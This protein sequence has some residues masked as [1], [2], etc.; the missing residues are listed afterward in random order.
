M[1]RTFLLAYINDLHA[2]DVLQYLPKELSISVVQ[3]SNSEAYEPVS[4]QLPVALT[5]L[6][7]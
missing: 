3:I 1:I 2:N 4:A 5:N 7:G 6:R